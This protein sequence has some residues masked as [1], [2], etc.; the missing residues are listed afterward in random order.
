[1]FRSGETTI[2]TLLL[3]QNLH[4]QIFTAHFSLIN[5]SRNCVEQLLGLVQLADGDVA[6]YKEGRQNKK[7]EYKE[8]HHTR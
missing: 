8:S 7:K 5:H 2:P 6:S 3:D 1:M 4:W